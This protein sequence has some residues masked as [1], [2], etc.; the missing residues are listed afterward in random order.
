[1]SS[2]DT[3]KK[4]DDQKMRNEIGI[5]ASVLRD[6]EGA[7]WAR[8]AN[9]ALNDIGDF[10]HKE[11]PE[12]SQLKY[13]GSACVHI[14]YAETL[15]QMVFITQTQP[16]LETHERMAGPA[17]TQLQKDMMTHYGRKTTKI[18]SGF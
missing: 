11:N 2:D 6:K 12:V 9:R 7:E 10:V 13:A 1:M 5:S 15:N 3:Q 17:F 14:Y 8:R 4:W 18:R 16:L